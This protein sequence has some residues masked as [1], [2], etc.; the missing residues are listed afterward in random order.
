MAVFSIPTPAQSLEQSVLNKWFLDGSLKHVCTSLF[1]L[2]SIEIKCFGLQ[3]VN[4][5]TPESAL[6][7]FQRI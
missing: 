7:S 6:H 1:P 5:Y 4:T 2:K 3:I